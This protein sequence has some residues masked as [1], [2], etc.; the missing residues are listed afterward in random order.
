MLITSCLLK[1][2][3][4]AEIPSP[5]ISSYLIQNRPETVV[6]GKDYPHG[7]YILIRRLCC[8]CCFDK[9]FFLPD[10][11]IKHQLEPVTQNHRFPVSSRC[12]SDTSTTTSYMAS[13]C[14][15]PLCFTAFSSFCWPTPWCASC[16]PI[17]YYLDSA[18]WL[19]RWTLLG[20]GVDAPLASMMIVGGG[21]LPRTTPASAA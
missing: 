2:Y 4:A 12:G 14:W 16:W 8:C 11:T 6:E 5:T 7:R 15:L 19:L 21:A 17:F 1:R 9:D 10:I 3:D 18:V 13:Y 20:G